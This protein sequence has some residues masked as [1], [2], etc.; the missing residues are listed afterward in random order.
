MTNRIPL[1]VDTEDGNKIKELP[2]GDG[3]NL[4]GSALFAKWSMMA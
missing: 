3:L 1:I 2:A 4:E